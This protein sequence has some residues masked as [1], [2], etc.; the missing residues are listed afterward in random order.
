MADV[1]ELAHL[2]F[3]HEEDVPEL[4]VIPLFE[5]LEDLEDVYKRQVLSVA[6]LEAEWMLVPSF[7]FQGGHGPTK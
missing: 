3:A 4:D 1:F 2:S 6:A 7:G 5:Q